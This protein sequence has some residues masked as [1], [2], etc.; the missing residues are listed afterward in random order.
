MDAYFHPGFGTR[1]PFSI[2]YLFLGMGVKRSPKAISK[3]FGF[4]FMGP[5]ASRLRLSVLS[6]LSFS[7]WRSIF[8]FYDFFGQI[9]DTRGIV[10]SYDEI[11]LYLKI[12]A[13]DRLSIQKI[14]AIDYFT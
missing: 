4:V 14:V 12:A 9:I 10:S 13:I 8:F 3:N 5:R 11:F 6:L 7:L 1:W 2:V